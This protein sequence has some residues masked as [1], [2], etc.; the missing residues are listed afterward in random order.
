MKKLYI[1]SL[2][3][4]IFLFIL[5]GVFFRKTSITL[6]ICDKVVITDLET[7]KETILTGSKLDEFLEEL[8]QIKPYYFKNPSNQDMPQAKD[9]LSV[10]FYK[11][12]VL[13]DSSRLYIYREGNREKL[14]QPYQIT[15]TL[16][17]DIM[18][19]FK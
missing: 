6:P 10:D 13:Q 2:F 15:V 19:Q 11:A 12:D 18:F 1:V 7:S 3:V 8:K 16:R 9:I 5:F 17:S 4:T 14:M